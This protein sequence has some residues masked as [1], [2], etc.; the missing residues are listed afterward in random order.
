M[1][2]KNLLLKGLLAFYLQSS[3]RDKI[4]IIISLLLA[5]VSIIITL[6]TPYLFKFL[7]MNAT[8]AHSS[9]HAQNIILIAYIILWVLGKINIFFREILI[10]RATELWKKTLCLSYIKKIFS[11]FRN[12]FLP[13]EVGDKVA[14]I[15]R[16]QN[17]VPHLILTTVLLLIPTI[18]EILV[19]ICLLSFQ[20]GAHLGLV[21]ILLF[22]LTLYT[23]RKCC[24]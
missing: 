7:I 3:R 13:F 5:V 2:I 15:E 18:I 6:L 21:T 9:I 20:Y 10:I 8:I 4:V 1:F 23:I 17:G 14:T 22:M 16:I 19:I 24:S 12:T 11:Q